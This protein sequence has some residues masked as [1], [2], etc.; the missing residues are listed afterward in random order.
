M[1]IYK[2]PNYRVDRSQRSTTPFT[3]EN[4]MIL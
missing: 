2:L 4:G 3:L 1:L